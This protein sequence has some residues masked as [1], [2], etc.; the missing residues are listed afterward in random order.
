MGGRGKKTTKGG[1]SKTKRAVA[2]VAVDDVQE[3]LADPWSRLRYV[4]LLQKDV[5]T[6]IYWGV[7]SKCG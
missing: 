6:A 5:H 2:R 4:E 7:P 3:E 1:R